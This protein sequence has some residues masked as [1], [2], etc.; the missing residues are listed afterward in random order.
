VTAPDLDRSV[1][2]LLAE[3]YAAGRR[4]RGLGPEAPFRWDRGVGID[5]LE[6]LLDAAIYRRERY[7]LWYGRDVARWPEHAHERLAQALGAVEALR[8]ELRIGP[9]AEGGIGSRV[10]PRSAI[11]GQRGV[12][13]PRNGG[14]SS[15]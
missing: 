9:L 12:P 2:E 7:R 13:L 8:L 3:R 15:C 10:E 11:V 5:E 14:Q 4:E 6:E 1:E